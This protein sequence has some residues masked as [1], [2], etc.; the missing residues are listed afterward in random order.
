[1]PPCVRVYVRCTI[2]TTAIYVV[3]TPLGF[4][5]SV[6]DEASTELAV[7]GAPLGIAVWMTMKTRAKR[8]RQDVLR[9]RGIEQGRQ[10]MNRT[11]RAEVKRAAER[12]GGQTG[13]RKV[14]EK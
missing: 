14:E 9:E 5:A 4:G 1:M 7:P 2:F 8:S 3:D 11:E 12:L 6:V 13:Q 10:R